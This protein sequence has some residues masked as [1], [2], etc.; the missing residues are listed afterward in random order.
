MPIDSD[1]TTYGAVAKVTCISGYNSS[2]EYIQCLSNGTWEIVTCEKIG[3]TNVNKAPY[4]NK[5]YNNYGIYNK[6]KKTGLSH[7]I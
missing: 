4:T 2:K 1:N 3:K 7:W 5:I 6:H